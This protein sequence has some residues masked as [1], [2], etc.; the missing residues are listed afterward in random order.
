MKSTAT[1]QIRNL[2]KEGRDQEPSKELVMESLRENEIKDLEG[3]LQRSVRA[4]NDAKPRPLDEILPE[5]AG[6]DPKDATVNVLFGQK[7]LSDK[8][9]L[10]HR[11]PKLPFVVGAGCYKPSEIRR[12]RGQ[13]LHYVWDSNL[14]SNGFLRAVTD[15]DEYRTFLADGQGADGTPVAYSHVP[16][17]GH[18]FYQHVN[19]GGY[20]LSL[21]Y[22]HAFP[23]LTGVTMSGWWFWATS[24]NDQISSLRTGSGPVILG[25]HIMNPYLTG[26]TMTVGAYASIPWI[27]QAWNDRVSAILG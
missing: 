20:V 2:I 4:Q 3:F 6:H 17:A 26:A 22:R 24:W 25:E 1:E 5:A 21:S 10:A 9:K 15:P 7:A 8:D 27:G 14:I 23:D 11:E 19:F 16:G 12:F 18:T 13:P